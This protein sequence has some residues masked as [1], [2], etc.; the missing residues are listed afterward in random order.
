MSGGGLDCAIRW[1]G[2]LVVDLTCHITREQEV[3]REIKGY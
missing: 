3:G 1:P 2:L